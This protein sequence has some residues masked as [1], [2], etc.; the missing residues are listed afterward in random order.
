MKNKQCPNCKSREVVKRGFFKTEV[1]GTRQRYFCKSC[2]KKFIEQDAFYRMRNTPQKIT[3]CLD[4]FYKGVSTRHIQEHLQSFYP[5]N[6]SNVSIYKWIVKY[7]KQI[8]KFT[9]SLKLN[10][11][12]EMQTDEMEY[13][14]KGRMAWFIDTIDT[15]TRFM[16]ASKYGNKRDM[17]SIRNVLNVAKR[18]TGNQI[19]IVTTDGFQ[20]YTNLVRKAFFSMK[21]GMSTVEHHVTN[22]S[23]GEGFNH[24]IERMHNTIRLRTKTFR[25][26]HGSTESA[27]S[28]MKGFEIYY[29]FIR[30]HQALNGRTPSELACPEL[31]LEGN[32][33]LRLIELSQ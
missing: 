33:W 20:V 30:K 4:L 17:R 8:G 9:D 24:K 18:K 1:H 19:K 14:T 22:A 6:S 21:A 3:L 11:G 13:K 25:G 15:K 2:G 28:I 31:K 32:R 29:N 5:H 16:V 26:F 12:E 27:D 23:R 7:S 10:V